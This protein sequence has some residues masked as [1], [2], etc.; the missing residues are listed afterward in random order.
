MATGG[1]RRW[2]A[3]KL[4]QTI[5]SAMAALREQDWQ[6]VAAHPSDDA[7]DYRDVDYTRGTAIVLGSELAG[8]DARAIEAADRT[9]TIPML[10]MVES[11]NVSVAAALI[12]Y[13]AYRQRAAAGMYDARRLDPKR[14]ERE[15]FEWAYPRIAARLRT[16]GRDYP[17]IGKDGELTGNPLRVDGDEPGA[18]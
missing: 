7:I 8:L 5:E 16:L 11:L 15:L 2:V 6:I 10:G 12:L 18:P 14:F 4:H 13:E 3:M 1:S 9:V 17:R